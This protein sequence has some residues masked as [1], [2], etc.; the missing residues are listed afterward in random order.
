[1]P[2]PPNHHLSNPI[3]GRGGAGGR[4]GWHTRTR[5]GPNTRRMVRGYRRIRVCPE[6]RWITL[7]G[8][9]VGHRALVAPIPFAGRRKARTRGG[10]IQTY[11]NLSTFHGCE[12]V[13]TGTAWPLVGRCTVHLWSGQLV[14]LCLAVFSVGLR[15]LSTAR[16]LSKILSIGRN[17]CFCGPVE[18][19]GGS[20]RQTQEP[21]KRRC[22]FSGKS[23]RLK[24]ALLRIRQ[25]Q[26]PW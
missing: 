11:V 13:R 12:V 17:L 14:V 2:R 26:W 3:G 25:W 4:A 21:S 10:A 22:L 5:S 24:Q 23:T 18:S 7:C 16:D 20:V 9:C 15:A 6:Q 8:A 19:C 1:M